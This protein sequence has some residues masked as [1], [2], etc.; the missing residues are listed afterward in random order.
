MP[1]LHPLFDFVPVPMVCVNLAEPAKIDAVNRAFVDTFGYQPDALPADDDWLR[2][3]SP[4]S[5]TDSQ[6][7]RWLTRLVEEAQCNR[8]GAQPYS[9]RVRCPDGTHRPTEVSLIIM[10]NCAV[11]SLQEP[12]QNPQ[13]EAKLRKSEALF[14]SFFN[15]PLVG[16]AITSVE[17]GWIE[18][19]DRTCEILGYSRGEL[20]QKNWAELTH[21]DDLGADVALFERMLVGEIDG[22]SLEKRFIRPDGSAI[23]CLL[24]GGRSPRTAGQEEFFYVQIIDISERKQIEKALQ[25]EK[26]RYRLLADNVSDNIWTIDRQGR[27]TY[28]SPSIEK[29]L[30]YTVEEALQMSSL[31]FL[32]PTAR[33]AELARVAKLKDNLQANEP[34]F[35]SAEVSEHECLRKDGTVIW[36]EVAADT[37][38][39]TAGDIIGITGVS[40][41]ITARKKVEQMLMERTRE[42][43]LANHAKTQFLAHMSHEIR[44]PMNAI[45][46]FAQGLAQA[47]LKPDQQTII[48]HITR[49]G[50]TLLGI[51]NDILDWSK[52][53]AGQL[54]LDI[55]PLRLVTLLE[56]IQNLFAAQA[57]EKGIDLLVEAP[58]I[59]GLL[60]CDA[61]RLEQ[62]L[63]NLT[64]NAIK[65]TQTGRV[66]IRVRKLADSQSTI[67]LRFEVEDTGIGLSEADR[68]RLFLPFSQADNTITRRFGGTGLGLSISRRLVDMMGGEI[69]VDSTEGQG[70]RFWFEIPFAL[71]EAVE[72]PEIGVSP[73]SQGPRLAGLRLLVVDDNQINLF[74]AEY[75]L[76]KE[77]AELV[78]L[79]DGQQALDHLRDNPTVA[80]LV[81]MDIQMPVMDG[82]TA[83]RAIREA[84]RLEQL[85]IIALSAG[86]L[87]EEKQ[88]AMDAGFNDFLPKPLDLEQ[89]VDIIHR[90]CRPE[91]CPDTDLSAL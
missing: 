79:Q 90:Y 7:G 40:R 18:V 81:L 10:D 77:G 19:N 34:A 86:V 16:T 41:D 89:M 29:L 69:S 43:E 47:D 62:V 15:L 5:A 58:P 8:A 22:Y 59:P 37:L 14:R 32:T 51:I 52:I 27:F 75:L 49:S 84:L 63:L 3:A 91:K 54:A 44:T 25:Q 60:L 78:L 2:P 80:D 48:Q 13:I 45:L 42:L 21:P 30:G 1:Q 50:R 85:P 26:E 11:L 87:T 31:D 67:R 64:G 57:R 28:M 53:E 66:T 76:E 17:K 39:N 82:L 20:F 88:Q 33:E 72:A 73:V 4:T 38:R 9:C 55:R 12:K 56:H 6:P 68:S 36:V 65:F 70:S 71:S 61:L 35:K 23:P 74:A 83:T 46:G 24:I